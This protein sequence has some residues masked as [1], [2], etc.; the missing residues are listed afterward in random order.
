M[1]TGVSNVLGLIK[2]A[3]SGHIIFEML[4]KSTEKYSSKILF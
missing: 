4:L 2:L 3:V 1:L